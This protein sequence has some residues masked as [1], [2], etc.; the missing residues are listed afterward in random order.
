MGLPEYERQGVALE[1]LT[2]IR[3][4]IPKRVPFLWRSHRD[5]AEQ[6]IAVAAL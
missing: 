3:P 5:G 6:S 2:C 1:G 4:K